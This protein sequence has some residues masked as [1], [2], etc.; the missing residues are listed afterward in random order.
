[1]NNNKRRAGFRIETIIII[2]IAGCMIFLIDF[3][4]NKLDQFSRLEEE[5][6]LINHDPN[7]IIHEQ[8]AEE[9]LEY[10]PDSYKM[11][12]IYTDEFDLMMTLQF[13]TA[14]SRSL[15]LHA[16]PELIDLFKNNAEGHTTLLFGNNDEIK[17]DVY[18]KWV[19]GSDENK[20][21]MIV[22]SS[23]HPVQNIW[24]F[25][26]VCYMVLLLVFVLL[27]YIR[28]KNYKDKIQQYEQLSND[29]RNHIIH[30]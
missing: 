30:K 28:L 15:N 5:A 27:L 10:R 29:V 20:Y 3:T 14:N 24:I 26:F 4:N 19:T 23:R 22:Y 11:I 2:L 13:I 7:N 18:F 1:M 12:E 17:E 8:L 16:H 25:N 9:L 21:L 6:M